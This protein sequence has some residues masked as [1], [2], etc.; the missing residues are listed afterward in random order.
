MSDAHNAS[1]HGFG[2]QAVRTPYNYIMTNI[3]T[4]VRQQK[5]HHLSYLREARFT[6]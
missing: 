4:C 3:K 1:G 6:H 5:F 2:C